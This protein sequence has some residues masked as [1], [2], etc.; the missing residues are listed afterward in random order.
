MKKWGQLELNQDAQ[1][2]KRLRFGLPVAALEEILGNFNQKWFVTAYSFFANSSGSIEVDRAQGGVSQEEDPDI[3]DA[4]FF[5]RAMMQ[6][7][8]LENYILSYKIGGPQLSAIG[9][10]YRGAWGIS[11]SDIS[12]DFIIAPTVKILTG[13]GAWYRDSLRVFGSVDDPSINT[14]TFLHNE[15]TYEVSVVD[16]LFERTLTLEE[17][18]NEISAQVMY[19]A[20]KL[21]KSR[22]VHF[23][24]KVDHS[25]VA[26][27]NP[28]VTNGLVTLDASASYSPD[29]TDLSFRWSQDEA[30]PEQVVFAGDGTEIVTFD[31]PSTPGEYYYQLSLWAGFRSGWARTVSWWMEAALILLIWALGILPGW[32]PPWLM[33]FMCDHSVRPASLA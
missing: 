22:S 1:E 6:Q 21:S 4:A 9:S 15:L 14:A 24:Y 11:P 27:I 10:E 17:G 13:G 18:D 3:Y 30:N 2:T 26:I 31:A 28:S 29:Q 25:P 19:N 23:D 32:I 7:K 8:L 12:D 20:D 16:G 33:R 5:P